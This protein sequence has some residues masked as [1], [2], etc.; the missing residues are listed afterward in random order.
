MNNAEKI[1]GKC[2]NCKSRY[3]VEKYQSPVMCATCIPPK[4]CVHGISS[5]IDCTS[6][7][8]INPNPHIR[9]IA[10]KSVTGIRRIH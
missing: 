1:K 8:K 7:L 10:K 9:V 5:F 4:Y 6:C 2:R 3:Y